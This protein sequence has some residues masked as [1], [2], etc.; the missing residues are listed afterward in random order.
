MMFPQKILKILNSKGI[1]ARRLWCPI[2]KLK[3]YK[4]SLFLGNKISLNFYKNC[5]SLPSSANLKK[6]EQEYVIKT[7][8]NLINRKIK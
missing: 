5:I 6:D 8:Q 1:Q 7:I 4:N 2:N 3:P